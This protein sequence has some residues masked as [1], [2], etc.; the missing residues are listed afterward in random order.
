MPCQIAGRKF[1]QQDTV[2]CGG[3]G[4]KRFDIIRTN[5]KVGG[6]REIVFPVDDANLS[7]AIYDVDGA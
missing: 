7:A 1:Q 6:N 2:G 4:D 3:G 5:V